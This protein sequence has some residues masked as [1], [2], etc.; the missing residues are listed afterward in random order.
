[1][2]TKDRKIIGTRRGK[3]GDL[4]GGEKMRIINLTSEIHHRHLL[5]LLHEGTGSNLCGFCHRL[6]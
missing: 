4:I 6:Y 1:M 2:G 5:H 3:G